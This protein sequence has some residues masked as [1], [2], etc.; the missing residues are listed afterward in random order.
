L[1]RWNVL[2]GFVGENDSGVLVLRKTRSQ[3]KQ[4]S[5]QLNFQFISSFFGEITQKNHALEKA[6]CWQDY[7][8]IHASLSSYLLYLNNDGQNHWAAAR[9]IIEILADLVSQ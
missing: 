9:F 4:N 8:I 3:R 1:R 2:G 5:S 7:S 6:K